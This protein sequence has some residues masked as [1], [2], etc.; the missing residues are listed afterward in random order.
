M[1]SRSRSR[2]ALQVA[3]ATLAGALMYA[4]VAVAPAA[5]KQ[6]DQFGIHGGP[7]VLNAPSVG[8]PAPGNI[9]APFTDCPLHNPALQQPAESAGGQQV[10]CVASVSTSGT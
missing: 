3:R 5:A 2:R 1:T 8:Y 10:G 7:N 6:A 9:Y 4:A